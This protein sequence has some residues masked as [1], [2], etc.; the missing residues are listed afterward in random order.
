V[1]RKKIVENIF[2][3][4]LYENLPENLPDE[5]KTGVVYR[6]NNYTLFL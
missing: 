2:N 5:R 4:Q 3:S 6:K 1:K